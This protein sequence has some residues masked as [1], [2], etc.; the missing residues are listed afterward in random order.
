VE[1]RIYN[2][3]GQV[4]RTLQQAPAPAG[5]HQVLWDG[6]DDQGRLVAGGIYLYRLRVRSDR[7]DN[8]FVAMRKVVIVP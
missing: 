3:L 8:E 6:R 1:L 4:V 2:L 5:Y 7:N